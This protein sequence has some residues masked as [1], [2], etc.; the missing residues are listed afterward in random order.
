MNSKNNTTTTGNP[1]QDGDV[2]VVPVIEDFVEQ[3]E[4]AIARRR[5]KCSW[6]TTGQIDEI[7]Q[8]I[9]EVRAWPVT[10]ST[11]RAGLKALSTS[12][13]L[14][15]AGSVDEL[16]GEFFGLASGEGEKLIQSM[17]R[18][19]DNAV[20]PPSTAKAPPQT[21]VHRDP[22]E[23]TAGDEEC[24]RETGI[25]GYKSEK[26]IGPA[27]PT[28]P[29]GPGR[30]SRQS[31]MNTKLNAPQ[32]PQLVDVVPVAENTEDR[33]LSVATQAAPVN[34]DDSLDSFPIVSG[35]DTEAVPLV[36]DVAGKLEMAMARRAPECSGRSA[37]EIA[38]ITDAIIK[39][40]NCPIVSS[41]FRAGLIR[42]Y[43]SK[44]YSIATSDF[45]DFCVEFFGIEP[46]EDMKIIQ[47]HP[48]S[49]KV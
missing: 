13:Y 16:C 19:R 33:E 23:N 48:R 7:K 10:S 11:F 4:A 32:T 22:P 47:C 31:P 25:D 43:T 18:H 35:I 40:A 38:R 24:R 46:G 37:Q 20:A 36:I 29:A 49:R 12:D 5:P 28:E 6:L 44:E 2:D 17:Q 30:K 9:I 8:R 34:R 21:P 15:A 14:V 26:V 45:D 3:L 39:L 42:L 41:P 27:H 1:M